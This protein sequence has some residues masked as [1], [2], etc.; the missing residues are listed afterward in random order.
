[1]NEIIK[2]H[3]LEAVVNG[4]NEIIKNM[5]A[6]CELLTKSREILKGITSDKYTSLIHRRFS[7]YNIGESFSDS[8][9]MV[10]Q[11]IWRH[12]FSLSSL[13]DFMSIKEREKLEKQLYNEDEA[14]GLPEPDLKT[15]FDT[16]NALAGNTDKM[17][18]EATKEVFNWLRPHQWD[19]YKTN[20]K[21]KIG[22]KVIKGWCM[23]IQWGGGLK[24]NYTY[25]ANIKAL[26]NVFSLLDGKGVSHYPDDIIT[27]INAACEAKQKS[28]EDDYFKMKWFKNGNLHVEFK[29][30]DLLNRLNQ[31]GSDGSL[32]N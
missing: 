5:D 32:G 27:R 22:P 29:R 26:E 18:T 25:E 10:K 4:Y 31:I 1:M 13:K 28:L 11:E 9:K 8:K 3:R 30:D 12:L 24:V 21:F 6:A 7:D 16:F 19:T 15:I 17:I 14:N 2:R 20:Q 23:S